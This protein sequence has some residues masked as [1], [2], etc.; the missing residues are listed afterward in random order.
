MKW[1]IKE[2][3]ENDYK[4]LNDKKKEIPSVRILEDIKFDISNYI[5]CI[6]WN[7]EDTKDENVGDNLEEIMVQVMKSLNSIAYQYFR[8]KEEI[9]RDTKISMMNNILSDIRWDNY[10]DAKE[11]VKDFNK[12]FKSNLKY[13]KDMNADEMSNQYKEWEASKKGAA[14]KVKN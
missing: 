7:I 8:T 2:L 4:L 1:T 10:D 9:L 6:I 11:G 5:E 12:K 14:S 13:H 3:L